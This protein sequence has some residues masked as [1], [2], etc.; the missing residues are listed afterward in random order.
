MS[1]EDGLPDLICPAC[2]LQLNNAYNFKKQCENTDSSLR[3][4][5]KI[6][7]SKM[8]KLEPSQNQFIESEVNEE[9]TNNVEPE[10]L[11]NDSINI[12]NDSNT[13]IDDV[14]QSM[15]TEIEIE[16]EPEEEPYENTL[17]SDYIQ[18][19]ENNQ[20][21][22]TCR[23]CSKCFTT[24]DG[25]KCHKRLH[26]GNL[27][28]CK[29]C[30]KQYT[31]QNHLYRHE[32]THGR[33]KVHVCKICSKT[34]T[35]FEHLKRHLV[36][37]LKEKPFSCTTCNRGFNRSEHLA[38]HMK[39]CKGDR[40]HICDICNKGFNRE[41]SL[42]VHKHLHDNK[43]P[44]LPTLENLDNIDQHYVEIE[45]DGNTNDHLLPYSDS[46]SEADVTD[47]LEPQVNISENT[48]PVK[49][50]DIP[51]VTN[52]GKK[53]ILLLIMVRINILYKICKLL[54]CMVNMFLKLFI[55]KD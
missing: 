21:L 32:M 44:I 38:N 15:K 40:V 13:D 14:D 48:D 35:R 9:I 11:E 30:G 16:Q 34:L 29:E 53:I 24:L 51:E 4:Y 25:L 46:D 54:C 36:T 39:R 31:R 26:T 43:M 8:V 47:C 5:I 28:K 50:T 20:L 12:L 37:H 27:F 42:E 1:S 41:D 55:L 33:R 2:T 3:Q 6:R 7:D 10:M 17:S 49:L 22:L 19:L 23:T 52:L 18:F 45:Y